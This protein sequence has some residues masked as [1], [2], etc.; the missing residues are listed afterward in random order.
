MGKRTKVSD[1]VQRHFQI[2][3]GG[4]ALATIAFLFLYR[5]G[6]AP[7]GLTKEETASAVTSGYVN[8]LRDIVNLPWLMWQGLF[9]KVL[10]LSA[11]SVRLPAAILG[12]AGTIVLWRILIKM[13]DR[14]SALFGALIA[15]T[16][17]LY[18]GLSRTGTASIMTILLVELVILFG[19]GAYKGER[20]LIMAAIC[21][22]LLIFMD[23][24]W[25]VA[26]AL[27]A[28]VVLHPQLRLW[29]MS[30]KSHL[31][32]AVI[33]GG[34]FALL[35]IGLAIIGLGTGWKCPLGSLGRPSIDN[36]TTSLGAMFSADSHLSGGLVT[37]FISIIGLALAALG[38]VS[39]LRDFAYCIRAYLVIGL[40]ALA[41]GLSLF[42]PQMGY[43]IFLP[44]ALSITV[45]ISELIHGWYG[46]FPRNPY[47]RGF[48]VAPLV[49]LICSLC[50]L[51]VGRYFMAINYNPAVAYGYNYGVS[52]VL[53][54]VN[55]GDDKYTLVTSDDEAPLYQ[56]IKAD[57]LSTE[58][59][60]PRRG[61]AI[62]LG[63]AKAPSG[64]KLKYV[65]TN[66][67]GHDNIVARVYE[68]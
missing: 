17:T 13:T 34:V 37:P 11:L 5:L 57:N 47:A 67:L 41:L 36:L 7:M 25:I 8:P 50:T 21:W 54:I 15:A 2:I 23:S 56:L 64:F 26:L 44:L 61:K 12:V 63:E 33:Y 3:I 24:G 38:L 20:G 4:L 46:I 35:Y 52:A 18:M 45:A 16:S 43:L 39:I 51:N 40:L 65:A 42:N 22:G 66:G 14:S 68:R 55:S 48:A 62:V 58:S 30:D 29:L 19:L 27:V 9:I 59:K 10:G 60:A 28:V 1:F 6:S 32:R 31:A 49:L 53:D